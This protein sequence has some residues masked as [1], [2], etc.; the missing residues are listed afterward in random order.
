MVF[1]TSFSTDHNLFCTS[2]SANHNSRNY[3][4]VFVFWKR[5]NING[6]LQSKIL[7]FSFLFWSLVH[8]VGAMLERLKCIDSVPHVASQSAGPVKVV[9][10]VNVCS[11]SSA[12][13]MSHTVARGQVFKA[14][15]RLRGLDLISSTPPFHIHQKGCVMRTAL[16][17][18]KATKVI[19]AAF[20]LAKECVLKTEQWYKQRDQLVREVKLWFMDTFFGLFLHNE[21]NI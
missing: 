10:G 15:C 13:S 9:E 6:A 19:Q 7:M 20:W 12:K 16:W 17:L 18:A 1:C 4:F 5:C 3:F 21:W 2:Y 8:A 11:S 14:L